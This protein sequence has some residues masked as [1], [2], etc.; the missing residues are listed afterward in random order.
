MPG[1][2]RWNPPDLQDAAVE[3][4]LRRHRHRRWGW[5]G[6]CDA[7]SAESEAQ[8]ASSVSHFSLDVRQ[9]LHD[10]AY[11][12]VRAAQG[13]DDAGVIA[14]MK[15]PKS[16]PVHP[17]GL[18]TGPM[19]DARGPAQPRAQ[20]VRPFISPVIGRLPLA[21]VDELVTM[22]TRQCV[23]T[24]EHDDAPPEARAR[25]QPPE[26][27]P[28]VVASCTSDLHQVAP[29]LPTATDLVPVVQHH[30][31]SFRLGI[32]GSDD[33]AALAPR[34]SER[35]AE[36]QATLSLLISIKS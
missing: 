17:F 13:L 31:V 19:I 8:L 11:L 27:P 6:R 4:V 2:Y 18:P 25:A 32:D 20:L 24:L 5:P 29:S 9:A 36:L 26:A 16:A 35:G 34:A 15:S 10:F 12:G 22:S 1:R 14:R 7:S 30:L 3:L 23:G 28:T 21:F 33:L